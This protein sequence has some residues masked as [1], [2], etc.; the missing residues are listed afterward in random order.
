[1]KRGVELITYYLLDWETCDGAVGHEL[2]DDD[3]EALCDME[4]LV[5]DPE[6]VFASVNKVETN[7]GTLRN[8]VTIRE[9]ER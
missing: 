1:M 5:S 2:Y 3:Y 7:G 4:G 9:Y 6:V 8:I